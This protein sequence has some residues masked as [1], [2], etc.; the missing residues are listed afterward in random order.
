METSE[1][2]SF[3]CQNRDCHGHKIHALAVTKYT[4]IARSFPHESERSAFCDE[5]ISSFKSEIATGTKRMCPR[6]DKR[7]V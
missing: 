4:V 1:K 7:G 6:D 3:W 5:A 2:V